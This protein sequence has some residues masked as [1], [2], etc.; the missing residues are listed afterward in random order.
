MGSPENDEII[1]DFFQKI[2]LGK[3][4]GGLYV[5]YFG[6]ER[7]RD[8]GLTFFMIGVRRDALTPSWKNYCSFFIWITK[9]ILI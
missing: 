1:L 8:L 6:M 9:I 4:S 2:D 3:R 5:C 7:V